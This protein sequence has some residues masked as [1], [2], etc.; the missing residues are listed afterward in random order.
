MQDVISAVSAVSCVLTRRDICCAWTRCQALPFRSPEHDLLLARSFLSFLWT[1]TSLTRTACSVT[2][3]HR[4]YVMNHHPFKLVPRRSVWKAR[5]THKCTV[6]LWEAG[7]RQLLR[8]SL[9]S[10]TVLNSLPM[11]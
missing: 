4:A 6:A 11:R 1:L 5:M 8:L 10:A 2:I 7:P 9:F 3:T